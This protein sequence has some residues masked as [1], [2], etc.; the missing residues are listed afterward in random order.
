[1][2]QVIDVPE[3]GLDY[4]LYGNKSNIV[5]NYIM[6]QIN[7]LPNVFN[8]FGQR[9]YNNLMTTYSFITDKL[10]QYGILN[11]LNK[12]GVAVID[13]YTEELLTF[14][15]LQNANLTMQRWVMAHP[16]VRQDFL[17]QNID[18]YSETYKNV[19][20]KEV[21]EKD[22]NYRLLMDGVIQDQDDSWV[23]KHYEQDFMEGDREL[24]HYD[25]VKILNTWDA[26]TWL[27][28]N[29]V[30]DFTVKSEEPV[31]RNIE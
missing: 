24:D 11:Q 4:V 30:F 29:C 5:G 9:I 21:G 2:G 18:G 27:H 20:G 19:F 25:K 13:N 28:N 23:I 14:Q 22:Y 16:L 15:A 31:K 7:S 17:N 3:A 8:E 12:A 1:M 10:T 26:I 6:N